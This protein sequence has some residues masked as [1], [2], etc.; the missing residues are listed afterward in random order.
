MTGVAVKVTEV[1]L[2]MVLPGAAAI[3]T[4][5]VIVLLTVMV[6]PGLVAVAAPAQFALL[7]MVT[8]ITSPVVSVL[9]V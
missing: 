8:V 5:G 3:V 7:V 6:I 9:S 4:D 1:P 2:Q